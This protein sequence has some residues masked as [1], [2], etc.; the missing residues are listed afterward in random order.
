MNVYVYIYRSLVHGG[1]SVG[2]R[3]WGVRL[4]LNWE[5]VGRRRWGSV[6]RRGRGV[7]RLSGVLLE[8]QGQYV[9]VTDSYII[10]QF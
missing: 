9:W 8:L 6:G 4:S 5:S 2:R 7:C 10:H 1:G 3:W